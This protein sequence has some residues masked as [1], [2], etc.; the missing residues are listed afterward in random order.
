MPERL[1]PL[2]AI[3]RNESGVLSEV[4]GLFTRRGFN[5]DSL[6]VGE[7]EDPSYSRMT[8]VVRGDDRAIEQVV[9][10]VNKLVDVIKVSDLAE[11]EHVERELAL[12][13]VTATEEH[14]S[15][16]IELADIFRAKIID[17]GRSSLIIEITGDTDKVRAME[18]MLRQF[19]I[20]ELARTGR[21]VLAR[22]ESK[23]D[24][25]R[26]RQDERRH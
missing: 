21:I 24:Q 26:S 1:H 17:V 2:A 8:I 15:E 22:G 6:A 9:K 13:K 20:K 4:A 12:I 25:V 23:R 10:Q 7:T 16:I 3:V 19:G 11:D 5:I 14:R 18:E